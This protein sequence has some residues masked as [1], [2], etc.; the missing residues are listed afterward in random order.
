MK[1]QTTDTK[2]AGI[3]GWLTLLLLKLWVGSAIR[4][5]SVF[6]APSHLDS[7]INAVFAIV[8]VA[9]A[10]LMTVKNSKGV[11]LAK[12]FFLMEA[13]YYFL[14]FAAER[15]PKSIGWTI[16]SLVWILYL[17]FSKRVRNTYY[18]E[19][20]SMTKGLEESHAEPIQ[21]R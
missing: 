14:D 3:G 15:N 21:T 16:G 1:I 17:F 13:L 8:G 18:P 19:T 7:T 6:V 2:L 5:V 10:Y 12:I 9:T 20:I 11:L 4:L